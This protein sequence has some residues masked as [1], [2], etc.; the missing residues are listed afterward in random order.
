MRRQLTR[1]AFAVGAMCLTIG[2]QEGYPP[3]SAPQR[4]ISVRV[5]SFGPAR[6]VVSRVLL[7]TSTYWQLPVFEII[8]VKAG[9][10]ELFRDGRFASAIGP[11]ATS[12]V[13][14]TVVLG[15][16]L[17]DGTLEEQ[18]RLGVENDPAVKGRVR[19]DPPGL[20]GR[21][22]TGAL[23][24]R[25]RDTGDA[26]TIAG[27]RFRRRIGGLQ[28]PLTFTLSVSETRRLASSLPSDLGLS[29]TCSYDAEFSQTDY[30][31]TADFLNAEFQSVW[32]EVL[33]SQGS[34]QVLFIPVGGTGD[35]KSDFV[36]RLV[37]QLNITIKRY[38][39]SDP[40][41]REPQADLVEAFVSKTLDGLM[42]KVALAQETTDTRLVFLLRNGI[43]L[44]TSIGEIKAGQNSTFKM[45]VDEARDYVEQLSKTGRSSSS[46]FGLQVLL[47]TGEGL[48]AKSSTSSARFSEQQK[49][50]LHERLSQ[51][52]NKL[53]QMFQGSMPVLT[54]M[55]LASAKQLTSSNLF[56]ARLAELSKVAT[57]EKEFSY[58][59]SFDAHIN[60][61]ANRTIED[62]QTFG[63]AWYERLL[64]WRT[65]R[66]AALHGWNGTGIYKMPDPSQLQ[67]YLLLDQMT[68]DLRSR[69]ETL[70]GRFQLWLQVGTIVSASQTGPVRMLPNLHTTYGAPVT[71]IPSNA[72]GVISESAAPIRSFKFLKESSSGGA[73]GQS[74]EPDWVV[75][76]P[77]LN[78]W[79]P[80]VKPKLTEY[81]FM[82]DHRPYA[83]QMLIVLTVNEEG[84]LEN[85]NLECQSAPWPRTDWYF[86]PCGQ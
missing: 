2:A 42:S 68:D 30:A 52:V 34:G 37:Q 70:A 85:L 61:T 55:N 3:A 71:Q 60:A 45:S 36:S 67:T 38:E 33:S 77:L 56:N 86:K 64:R 81:H 35:E 29:V 1:V 75:S 39:Q 10:G 4:D 21:Y 14:V 65:D 79:T 47:P 58:E 83:G 82:A 78:P 72:V 18:V 66:A 74:A 50:E 73:S 59:Y 54:G 20:A 44:M 84:K 9:D 12:A 31:V 51:D 19:R 46:S 22:C 40:T 43:S 76:L 16:V 53:D 24:L 7:G 11:Q 41:A 25:D 57:R 8:S 80:P 62:V 63:L 6:R 23:Q 32:T 48:G 26:S 13:R 69:Y 15:D 28:I 49:K 27:T 17:A 5:G